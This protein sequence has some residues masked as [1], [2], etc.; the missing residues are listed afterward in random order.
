M[1]DYRDNVVSGILTFTK[2][3]GNS[4]L[5]SHNMLTVID[6]HQLF[7][8]QK[9]S[10]LQETIGHIHSCL[11]TAASRHDGL[12]LLERMVAQCST[13]VFTA[14]VNT[15]FKLLLQ[16][17][18]SHGDVTE[19]QQ[20]CQIMAEM[21]ATTSS[22]PEITRE[23]S[24]SIIP[25][26]LPPLLAA[27]SAW[28]E[29]ATRCIASCVSY[30][31]GPCRVFRLK[32]ESM[33]LRQLDRPSPSN[34][35]VRCLA[36]L[37]RLGPSQGARQIDG[38]TEMCQ[39]LLSSLNHCLSCLYE[40]LE[41]D[42]AQTSEDSIFSSAPDTEPGRS[43]VLTAQF[44]TLGVCLQT[45]LGEKHTSSVKIPAQDILG[46]VCRCLA[47]NYRMLLARP[48]TDRIR[49]FS[50]LPEL[51]KSSLN[52]LTAL[53]MSCRMQL[54]PL[55]DLINKLF[56]QSLAFTHLDRVYALDRPL[57]IPREAT[58]SSMTQWL[59]V[60][61]GSCHL[62]T[63]EKD[64]VKEILHDVTPVPDTLKLKGSQKC[65]MDPPPT[66]K[67]KRTGY[68]EL[69]EGISSYR[70]ISRTANSDVTNS[71]LQVLHLFVSRFGDVLK[72]KN[73]QDIID[74]VVS[75]VL[76]IQQNVL[77][78]PVPYGSAECRRGLYRTLLACS[79]QTHPKVAS[80]L[81]VSLM[82]FRTGLQDPSI[83]V[84]YMC[85]EALTVCEC[86][87]HPR[88]PCLRGPHLTQTTLTVRR[89]TVVEADLNGN[90][91]ATGSPKVS[92]TH[93]SDVHTNSVTSSVTD[94]HRLESVS[95]GHNTVDNSRLSES[96]PK[97]LNISSSNVH[98][99]NRTAPESPESVVE[100]GVTSSDGVDAV[101]DVEM[102]DK[103]P[104]HETCEEIGSQKSMTQEQ[105]RSEL[106]VEKV[107]LSAPMSGT[108]M[109]EDVE[110]KVLPSTS[111][112]SSQHIGSSNQE[113]RSSEVD[114]M[115]LSFVDAGPDSD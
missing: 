3:D 62:V 18:Q 99:T 10:Y 1:A 114:A 63:E 89:T 100:E 20:S 26:L 82:L 112:E 94:T 6:H 13:E 103:M 40:G 38:W 61:G 32:I 74:S 73:Y 53:I 102:V 52:V 31:P 95:S 7:G 34:A 22:F 50:H 92:N 29:A 19:K 15:W 108:E 33:L 9:A 12:V 23:I 2:E 67:K 41:T 85:Q 115:L 45:L 76:V 65:N 87:V 90:N 21:I 42:E 66:K 56:L 109:V 48:T 98:L 43:S 111:I 14:N 64:L 44:K 25:K 107:E 46:V 51:H 93:S 96:V 55:S 110:G 4:S 60:V 37:A 80:P 68:Q 36:L 106:E 79:L 105:G 17:L 81:Q 35:G 28:L 77:D 104:G 113:I 49:L 27:T 70:K 91:I 30:F 16:V 72:D 5:D 78:A 58:Y 88:A 84:S 71:A 59:K 57:S 11:N 101:D 75:T 24:A 83:E 69:S 47:V 86:L 8:I 39:R 97:D 54:L